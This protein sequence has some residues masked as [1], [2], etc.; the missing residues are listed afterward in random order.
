MLLMMLSADEGVNQMLTIADKWGNNP[1]Y[2]SSES[3]KKRIT[4]FTIP[5]DGFILTFL[6]IFIFMTMIIIETGETAAF[7]SCCLGRLR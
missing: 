6:L 1:F 2:T 3:S 7:A 4:T 5:G